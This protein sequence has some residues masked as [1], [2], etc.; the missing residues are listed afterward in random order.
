LA[1]LPR[2]AILVNVARGDVVDEEALYDALASGHLGGAGLDVWYRYPESEEA[3][4]A[5]LPARRPF[6][7]LENVVLSPHRA[8]HGRGTEAA[9]AAHLARLLA[10]A[11]GG[12]AIPHRVDLDRGY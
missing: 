1:R 5:T 10:A 3:R 2:G 4:A 7:E 6:H 8:G 9:R 12:E 11:A